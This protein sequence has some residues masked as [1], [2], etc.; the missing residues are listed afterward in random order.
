M[1]TE[2]SRKLLCGSSGSVERI[3]KGTMGVG[4]LLCIRELWTCCEDKTFHNVSMFFRKIL[5]SF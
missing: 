1:R 5:A 2:G 3:R 4:N